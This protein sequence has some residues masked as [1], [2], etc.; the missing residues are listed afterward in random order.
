MRPALPIIV[1]MY[2][3]LAVTR[4]FT[5]YKLPPSNKVTFELSRSK[6]LMGWYDGDPHT[7]AISTV[8]N[9][10]YQKCLETMAHEM[11]HLALEK[12]GASDHSDHDSEFNALAADV[13][14]AWGWD[15]KGF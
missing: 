2:E 6:M 4:P 3:M 8:L 7:I 5:R 13:C 9:D 12:K 10:T 1:Q 11:V 14:N 15:F